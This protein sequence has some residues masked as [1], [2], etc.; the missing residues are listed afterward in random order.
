[1]RL[2]FSP[3]PDIDR[4]KRSATKNTLCCWRR[5]STTSHRFPICM[6][7]RSGSS[8]QVRLARAGA[9]TLA[10]LIEWPRPDEVHGVKWL[11]RIHVRVGESPN[12][13][14]QRVRVFWPLFVRLHG[15]MNNPQDYKELPSEVGKEEKGE[16][17]EHV[18]PRSLRMLSSPPH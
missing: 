17:M 18:R 2:H 1:M 13:Y 9:L 6:A 10:P 15:L 7:A 12:F 3:L 11:D 14:M 8:Y 5:G 4:N 16:A